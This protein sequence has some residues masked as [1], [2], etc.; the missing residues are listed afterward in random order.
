MGVLNVTPDSYFDGGR[1][2]G[3]RAIEHFEQLVKQGAWLVDIGGESSRPAASPVP[4]DE[5]IRRIESVVTHACRSSQVQVSVD[6]TSPE[7]ADRMLSL[8]V[9]AINDVSC[10]ADPELARVVA[11]HGAALILMHARGSMHNMAGFSRYP[12]NGYVDVIGEVAAEWEAARDRAVAQG[13]SPQDI[14][15]D[16]GLGFAKNAHHSER[17]LT[18]LCRFQRLGV[19]IVVGCSRKSFLECVEE[20]PPERR[21]GATVAACLLAVDGGASMLRVHDVEVIR[22]AVA[23]HRRYRQLWQRTGAQPEAPCS[24]AW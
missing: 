18:E 21:L 15:F 23:A 2:L 4:A 14:L 17:L 16:P 22:Q 13:V 11:R 20:V 8:G 1:H 7:V 5:Q 12:E 24:A 10:L 9:H 19:P 6:T 3:L